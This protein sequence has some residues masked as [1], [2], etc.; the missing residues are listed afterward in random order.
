MGCP[1]AKKKDIPQGE[2]PLAG[3]EMVMDSRHQDEARDCP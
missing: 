3:N 2:G 1:T